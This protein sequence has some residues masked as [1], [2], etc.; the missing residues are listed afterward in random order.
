MSTN[1]CRRQWTAESGHIPL[2]AGSSGFCEK[3]LIYLLYLLNRLSPCMADGKG[4]KRFTEDFTN[5][6]YRRR[7]TD[8]GGQSF[9]V[10]IKNVDS[11]IDN[12]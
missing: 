3:V 1:H 9:T 2:G 11:D 7:N 12:R 8:N 5:N 10:N 4:R 6:I